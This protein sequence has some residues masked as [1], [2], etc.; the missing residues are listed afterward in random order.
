MLTLQN[1]KFRGIEEAPAGF[2]A[3]GQP[4]DQIHHSIQVKL[5]AM[6]RDIIGE[7]LDLAQR[8]TEHIVTKAGNLKSVSTI[9]EVECDVR[10]IRSV[11]RSEWCTAWIVTGYMSR[12]DFA[13]IPGV[14]AAGTGHEPLHKKRRQGASLISTAIAAPDRDCANP[15]SFAPPAALK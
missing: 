1:L 8:P 15:V 6:M 4:C 5:D 12:S 13:D 2:S 11:A 10:A 9:Q 3:T 7:Q 14:G